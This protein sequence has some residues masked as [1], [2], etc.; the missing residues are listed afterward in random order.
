MYPLVPLQVVV[1]IETLRTLIASER[2]VVLR[3]LWL[4]MAVHVLH[5]RCMTTVEAWH[6]AV[7][8]T[9]DQGKLA[10]GIVNVR[11]NGPRHR[12]RIGSLL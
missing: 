10:T 12:V 3:V 4:R 6:H 9:A 2:S 7:R 8:Y 11:E 1:P 5:V